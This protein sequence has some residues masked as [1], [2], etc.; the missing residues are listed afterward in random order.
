MHLG[1][2][3]RQGR[4]E[5][6]PH[7]QESA[8]GLVQQPEGSDGRQR[9]RG[10]LRTRPAAA[11][12]P[13]HARRRL[14]AGLF[15]PCV[16]P[17]HALQADRYWPVQGRRLQAQ[18]VDQ[19]GAQSRL[20]E[21]GPSLSRRHRLEDRAQPQHAHAGFR[22]RRI[23]HDVRLRR[24]LPDAGRRQG[25]EGG[26]HLR[27]AAE[28]RQYQPARQSRRA[29][30]R[31]ARVAARSQPGARPQGVQRHPVP[32]PCADQRVDAAA[33]GRRVGHVQGDAGDH[34]G[35]FGRPV[36]GPR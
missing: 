1:R 19:A 25:A 4:R 34:A 5:G 17:R 24:H 27:S 10:H 13:V 14:L 20:L 29:A 7:P 30:V 36:K 3:D 11:V 21:E 32:G 22:G 15:L 2:A 12:L 16:R 31:Q 26:R 18:R 6:R 9:H 28:Q 23:R 8:Q 33:A 35:L